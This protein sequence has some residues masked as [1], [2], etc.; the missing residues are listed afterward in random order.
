MP[1][2]LNVFFNPKSIAVIGA[3]RSP[4]K[5]GSIVLRNIINSGFKG[6]IYPINPNA[7]ELNGKKCFPD[8][9]SIPDTCDL[10]VISLP[11]EVALEVISQVAKKGIKNI[12]L[13]ASGFKEIGEEGKVLEEKLLKLISDSGLN[14]LGPNCLGFVN[15]NIGLIR[16]KYNDNI[17]NILS[18]YFMDRH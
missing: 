10:V 7:A 12:V 2:D 8:I 13:Y 14:L 1:K 16:I 4:E 11:S 6:D 15:N 3:S 5:V 18:P 9:F 17:D